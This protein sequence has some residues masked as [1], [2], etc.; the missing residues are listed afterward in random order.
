MTTLQKSDLDNVAVESSTGFL[1]SA[2][3]Y[4]LAGS[5]AGLGYGIVALVEFN[6]GQ[7]GAIGLVVLAAG[8]VGGA[9]VGFELHRTRSWRRL[10]R[11]ANIARWA[12]AFSL[13]TGTLASVMLLLGAIQGSEFWGTVGFGS[14]L[15]VGFG[16]QQW[17]EEAQE[18]SMRK[19]VSFRRVAIAVVASVIVLSLL[20]FLLSIKS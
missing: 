6:K 19:S 20:G 14:V 3:G 12:V 2:A 8:I 13:T 16:L 5:V 1:D 4:A 15:G 18:A 7:K 11:L 17:F 9:L 10:G